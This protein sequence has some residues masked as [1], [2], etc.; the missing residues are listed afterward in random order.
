VNLREVG[1]NPNG[2]GRCKERQCDLFQGHC[3]I[4]NRVTRKVP[5]DADSGQDGRFEMAVKPAGRA[6][7][8]PRYSI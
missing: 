1:H 5:F 8:K 3:T 4:S 2:V 7:S 6:A